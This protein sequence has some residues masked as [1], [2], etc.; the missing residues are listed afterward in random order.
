MHMHAK[1]SKLPAWL[2]FFLA[3]PLGLFVMLLYRGKRLPRLG[4]LAGRLPTN[5][6]PRYSEPDSIPLNMVSEYTASRAPVVGVSTQS[7]DE[8]DA[9]RM[10]FESPASS[11]TSSTAASSGNEQEISLPD[12][13][14]APEAA[15]PEA[16]APEAAAPETAAP[17]VAARAAAPVTEDDLKRIEGIGPVIAGLLREN[18]IFTFRQ[19]AD[20]PTERLTALLTEAR[21]NRLS[22]PATWP[23]QARLAAEGQWDAL[24]QLQASL[25][26][27]RRTG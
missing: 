3:L 13:T 19:L 23:E 11:Y 15:A 2:W 8:L 22:D 5:P 25:K 14:P 16:A 21:L 4:Q 6:R 27:G 26:G 17:E 12:L 7:E 24:E 20:T 10:D 18:G 1:S 9:E